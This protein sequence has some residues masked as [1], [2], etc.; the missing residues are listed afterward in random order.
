MVNSGHLGLLGILACVFAI[1][2]CKSGYLST[3]DFE[4]SKE[5]YQLPE[6]LAEFK[7]DE[8]G[9]IKESYWFDYHGKDTSLSC[10]HRF[11]VIA[12]NGI[13]SERVFTII[14]NRPLSP[15]QENNFSVL[16]WLSSVPT[17]VVRND[18][19]KISILD[20]YD[21]IKHKYHRFPVN[22][23]PTLLN[24]H[25]TEYIEVEYLDKQKRILTLLSDHGSQHIR[26]QEE[27]KQLLLP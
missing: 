19:F 24:D 7:G 1:T 3:K 23:I 16:N 21:S 9:S 2:G 17:V 5:Q 27:N 26:L 4:S 6:I 14:G 25:S 13:V 11:S 15:I 18:S 10:L 12:P 20:K 8:N 22:L